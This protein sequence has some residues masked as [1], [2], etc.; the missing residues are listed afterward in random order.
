MPDTL[1]VV[2]ESYPQLQDLVDDGVLVVH[3]RPDDYAERRA[4][5]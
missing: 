2:S 4:D 5:G 3:R 1:Q